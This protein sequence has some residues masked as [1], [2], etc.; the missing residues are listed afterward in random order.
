VA[1]ARSLTWGDPRVTTLEAQALIPIA[2]DDPVE[3]GMREREAEIPI[4]LGKDA[5]YR[6]MFMQAFPAEAE[7]IDM[8]KVTR[9]LAAFQRSLI[10]DRAPYD[11]WRAGDRSA[12]GSEAQRGERLF[13]RQCAS[14]HSGPDLTDGRFH[15]AAFSPHD[16]GLAKVTGRARDNGRFRT[17]G[18]RNVGLTAPYLHDGSAATLADAIA[19]H[20]LKAQPT[21]HERIALIAFLSALTDAEF[22][23]DPR[24]ALPAEACGAPL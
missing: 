19:A 10:S 9:A 3:M 5:C 4:R 23:R 24:Y 7:A 12:L 13:A 21:E 1:W 6:R 15:S 8:D 17:P 18:L 16:P 11:R 22:A 14:C 2:G 20:P